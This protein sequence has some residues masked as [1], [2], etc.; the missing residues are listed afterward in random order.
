[1]SPRKKIVNQF[2]GF[3]CITDFWKIQSYL[4]PFELDI[5]MKCH[6]WLRITDHIYPKIM[7]ILIYYP[8]VDFQ[9]L[10]WYN[11]Q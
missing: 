4:I 11:I 1:M 10:L 3:Y 2:N 5:K 9:L 7:A 8:P 6:Q